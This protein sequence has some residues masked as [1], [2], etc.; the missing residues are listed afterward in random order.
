MCQGKTLRIGD[1]CGKLPAREVGADFGFEFRIGQ[2]AGLED[3]G[4]CF[5]QSGPGDGE[6]GVVGHGIGGGG[7]R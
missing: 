2:V 5:I 4:A 1:A 3:A 7:I 6:V